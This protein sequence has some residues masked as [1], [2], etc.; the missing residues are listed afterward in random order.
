MLAVTSRS[1]LPCVPTIHGVQLVATPQ[2]SHCI[3]IDVFPRANTYS[4]RTILACFGFRSFAVRCQVAVPYR[5][6]ASVS[7]Y[8]SHPECI[9]T[10][11]IYSCFTSQELTHGKSSKHAIAEQM[12]ER[13]FHPL[14]PLSVAKNFSCRCSIIEGSLV[15]P[16][17]QSK[18]RRKQQTHQN[19]TPND[20][21]HL[22]RSCLLSGLS[23][24]CSSVLQVSTQLSVAILPRARDRITHEGFFANR[25]LAL[26]P[27]PCIGTLDNR[28]I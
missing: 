10:S 16:S 20:A 5:F 26:P 27:F 14:L 2:Q 15:Q 12:V 13:L 19:T 7:F 4:D 22:L 18:T 25:R 3:R 28:S 1:L 23:P 17:L 9:S 24:A 8:A 21:F 11:C 6:R